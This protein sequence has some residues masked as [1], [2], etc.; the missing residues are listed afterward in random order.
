MTPHMYSQIRTMLHEQPRIETSLEM[1]NHLDSIT[2]QSGP[3]TVMGLSKELSTS[4]SE[5]HS[6]NFILA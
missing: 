1:A 3:W 4:V 6:A 2:A 5:Q